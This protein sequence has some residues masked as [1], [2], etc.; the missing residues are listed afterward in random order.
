MSPL[1]NTLIASGWRLGNCSRDSFIGGNM[2]ISTSKLRAAISLTLTLVVMSVFTFSAFAA[3]KRANGPPGKN[4]LDTPVKTLATASVG[5]LI[6]TGRFS[7]DGNE[8]PSGATV[9]SGSVIAT[10]P[11]GNAT[12][13]LGPLGRVELRPNTTITLVLSSNSVQVD[14]SGDGSMAQWLPPGVE[15]QI[16]TSSQVRFL[17]TRGQ[18]EVKSAQKTRK[19]SAG[20]AGTFND[21][22]EAIASGDAVLIAESS[23][24]K[25]NAGAATTQST[26]SRTVSAG[27]AGVAVLTGLAGA[28]AWG[29]MANRNDHAA[30]TLPKPSTVVP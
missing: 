22:A 12:I 19:L 24:S 29:V 11:D 4:S 21:P 13:D 16:R 10:G 1:V 3:S 2:T 26:P 7:I 9:L 17:V 20:E 15:G 27:P 18:A 30:T 5:K 8:V 14:M 6:G 23:R 25:D 28:V